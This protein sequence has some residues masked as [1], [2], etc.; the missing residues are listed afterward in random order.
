MSKLISVDEA[1]SVIVRSASTPGA[2]RVDLSAALGRR[3]AQDVLADVSAPPA[4]VSAMDGYAVR[5]DDVASGSLLLRVTGE[6][7]AGQ[8]PPR[9]I[10]PGEAMRIFTGAPVPDGAD[11]ILIQEEA[12]REGDTVHATA[13]QSVPSHVRIA[14]RDFAS[15]EVLIRSGTRMGPS[16]IAL[17]AAGNHAALWVDRRTRVAI[18]TSG[19]ELRPSG[20]SL[21]PGQIIDSVSPAI[22][23]LVQ[24]WGGQAI[25]APIARDSIEAIGDAVRAVSDAE[26]IVAVGG[27]SVG[28]YDLM[29]AAF[30]EAAADIQFA[31]VAVRPGKPTWFARLGA[32][33][34]LG[35]PG[36]PAS[37]YVC[38]HLFL[39][40]L[41]E[42]ERGKSES[43]AAKL[44]GLLEAEGNRE[45]YLRA[46]CA[47][48]LDGLSVRTLP[49]QD[50]SLLRPLNAANCLVRR[51][52][53]SPAAQSGEIVSCLPLTGP[54]PPGIQVL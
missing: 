36:N 49:D 9:P 14:G 28:D 2:E 46:I 30:L 29:K 21:S 32:Q 51:R 10:G 13:A 38:A 45:T 41:L 24:A 23:A 6:I 54:V 18:I 22:G 34:V 16:E 35:L 20:T 48:G 1:L 3:L 31:G 27:A 50:S 19:D 37:A 40:P 43:F 39:K 25:F 15:G 17:A 26:I 12:V 11:H 8:L 4:N 47:A 42:G 53:G 33:R 5:F 44:A 52:P 7:P